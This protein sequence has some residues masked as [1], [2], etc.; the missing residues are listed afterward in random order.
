VGGDIREGYLLSVTLSHALCIDRGHGL[1]VFGDIV[2]TFSGS[3]V[4]LFK[5]IEVIL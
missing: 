4:E 2:Y 5:S 3:V 1:Q